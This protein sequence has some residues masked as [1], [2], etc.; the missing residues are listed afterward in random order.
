VYFVLASTILTI[1]LIL[2]GPQI[3]F[4]IPNIDAFA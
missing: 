4:A 3:L 2:F 1:I